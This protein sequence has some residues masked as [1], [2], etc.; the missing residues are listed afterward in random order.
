MYRVSNMIDV[1]FPSNYPRARD[2]NLMITVLGA[3]VSAC[4][5]SPVCTQS[6]VSISVLRCAQQLSA[7]T[8]VD[9]LPFT[10]RND[11]RSWYAFA[12]WKNSNPP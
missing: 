9:A 6:K 1:L 12:R 11:V 4:L 2:Q 7:S 10:A 3:I 5:C 8:F